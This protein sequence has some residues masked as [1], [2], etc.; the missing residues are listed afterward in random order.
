MAEFF[1]MFPTW[2]HCRLLSTKTA[3]VSTSG[4]ATPKWDAT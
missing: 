1:Q 3:V 4:S 2:D